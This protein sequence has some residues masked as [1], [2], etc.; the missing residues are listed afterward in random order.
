M[1]DDSRFRKF[2][3]KE[4]SKRAESLKDNKSVGE[5]SEQSHHVEDGSHL[6]HP[7]VHAI[8]QHKLVNDLAYHLHHPQL[9]GPKGPSFPP[10]AK[11]VPKC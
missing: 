3:D 1:K 4:D 5:K 6:D 8:S 9:E 11:K 2:E 7:R 10:Q